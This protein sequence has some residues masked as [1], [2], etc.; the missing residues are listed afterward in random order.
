MH[1]RILVFTTVLGLGV[2]A[3]LWTFHTWT[4]TAPTE[5]PTEPTA[6]PIRPEFSSTFT[7][8]AP[9]VRIHESEDPGRSPLADT[10]G[11]P[12]GTVARDLR[13]LEDVF[14]NYR[15]ALGTNPWG[16]N[17]EIVTQLSGRN[18]RAHA[19]LPPDHPAIDPDG[20]LLDRWGTPFFFHAL[21][22]RTMEVRSAG[23]DREFYTSDD[24]VHRPGSDR[25]T[26]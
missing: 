17:A 19:P 24:A 14:S 1:R 3:T 15:L 6:P 12:D 26:P 23:P 10:L 9:H 11:S 5:T 7:P 2:F 21:D 13:V 20:R 4:R 18:R 16:D 8:P 22:A 25:P